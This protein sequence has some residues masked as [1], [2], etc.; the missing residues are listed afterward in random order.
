MDVH[1]ERGVCIYQH[2]WVNHQILLD[3]TCIL[4][5]F[6]NTAGRR[7]MSEVYDWY[8]YRLKH[9]LQIGKQVKTRV[10]SLKMISEHIELRFVTFHG[11]QKYHPNNSNSI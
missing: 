4:C 6:I 9:A 10:P 2:A 3:L 1:T 7:N 5:Y 11:M 8:P